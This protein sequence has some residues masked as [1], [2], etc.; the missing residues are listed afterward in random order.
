MLDPQATAI[1]VSEES[2]TWVY[3]DTISKLSTIQVMSE[4]RE[5]ASSTLGSPTLRISP[6]HHTPHVACL[7]HQNF[8]NHHPGI[9]YLWWKNSEFF[10]FSLLLVRDCCFWRKRR[11]FCWILDERERSVFWVG[12]GFAEGDGF[13]RGQILAVLAAAIAINAPKHL[14]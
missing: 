11:V 7:C 9:P 10:F 12:L 2:F 3:A 13:E 6:Q 1:H 4:F 8:Q 5:N 14:F